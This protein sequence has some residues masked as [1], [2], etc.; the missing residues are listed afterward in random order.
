MTLESVP[1]YFR[2]IWEP[3]HLLPKPFILERNLADHVC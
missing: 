1:Q 3:Q 2:F